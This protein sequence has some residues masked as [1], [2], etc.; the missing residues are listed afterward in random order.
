[1]Y[2]L[3]GKIIAQPG[4]RDALI[5]HLLSGSGDM[6]GNHLYVVGA[7]QSDADAIWIYEVWDSAEHHR[8]SL[9][10]PQVQAAITAARP[11]IAGFADRL[12]FTPVGGKGL[13][14]NAK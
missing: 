11:L 6:P 13:P 7:D 2:G 9:N 10:L 8:T 14:E 4:Q 3:H 1:M 12:E 5:G